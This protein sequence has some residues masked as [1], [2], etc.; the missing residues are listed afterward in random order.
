MSPETTPVERLGSIF[1]DAALYADPDRLVERLPALRLLA[2]PSEEIAGLGRRLR[3]AVERALAEV[4]EVA[5]I[6]TRSQIGS[7][8][9]PVSLLPSTALALRPQG[10]RP[11]S[12]VEALAR[13]LRTLP[14]P[15][16]GRIEAG[17]VLLDLRCLEDET[18]FLGQLDALILYFHRPSESEA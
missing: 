13:A 15:V 3:P 4:A 17:R 12:A 16:I 18:A 5:L 14:I 2:R 9:L 7:G 10:P 8:A 1:A 6:E 11:G